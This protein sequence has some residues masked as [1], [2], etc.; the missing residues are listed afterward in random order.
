MDSIEILHGRGDHSL[1]LAE[2]SLRTCED[3]GRIK[4]SMRSDPVREKF[5]ERLAGSEDLTKLPRN[6]VAVWEIFQIFS[7]EKP[8]HCLD[9]DEFT[10]GLVIVV[11]ELHLP[12]GGLGFLTIDDAIDPAS[13]QQAEEKSFIHQPSARS[14]QP[15]HLSQDFPHGQEIGCHGQVEGPCWR[16]VLTGDDV[17]APSDDFGETE[18]LVF[19][20]GG[21]ELNK[22]FNRWLER[23]QPPMTLGMGD[24]TL[25][26]GKTFRGSRASAGMSSFKIAGSGTS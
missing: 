3:G 21:D 6:V 16:D 4:R 17:V 12:Q 26:T 7:K 2:L 15:F 11:M 14:R 9:I 23:H 10:I 22:I 1:N 19:Q 25:C 5:V 8:S 24:G 13:P 20:R 18:E